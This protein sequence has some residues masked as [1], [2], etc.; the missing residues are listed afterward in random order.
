MA[1]AGA[2][3]IGG[4]LAD[5]EAHSGRG[6]E[7]EEKAFG[8]LGVANAVVEQVPVEAIGPAIRMATRAALPALVADGGIVEI[9]LAQPGKVFRFQAVL[10]VVN[11]GNKGGRFAG[12][13]RP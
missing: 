2:D 7:R 10:R 6:V 13:C 4:S 5:T 9:E 11:G 1:E 8:V 3:G 12:P